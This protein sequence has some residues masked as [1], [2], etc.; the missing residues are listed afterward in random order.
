[1]LIV[2]ASP[3]WSFLFNRTVPVRA[4]VTIDAEKLA[5]PGGSCPAVEQSQSGCEPNLIE[6]EILKTAL[7][8]VHL[9]TT[10]VALPPDRS[11]VTQKGDDP[12]AVACDLHSS[13]VEDWAVD[14]CVPHKPGLSGTP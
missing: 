2:V 7:R 5:G 1:V 6:I 4:S 9:L 3:C 14:L 10:T 8:R 11:W 12:I 13:A